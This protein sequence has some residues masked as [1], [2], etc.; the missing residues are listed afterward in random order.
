[1]SGT[2]A[3]QHLIIT[4]GNGYIG[5]AVLR[6]AVQAGRTVCVLGRNSAAVPAGARVCT[7]RLGEALPEAALR[8]DV[9]AAAQAV[10]HLAHDWSNPAGEDGS[11]GLNLAGTRA[12]L[13]GARHHG[14]GRFVF[15]SSQSARQDAANIYGRVKWQVE[16][17]LERPGEVAARIGLVYGGPRQAMFGLLCNLVERAP[18]LPMIDPWRQ[19]QP[20]HLDEVAT[21]LRLLADGAP[22]AGAT[23]W[24]GLAA[25]EG[26][27]FG[28]FLKTL[29]REFA[30]RTLPVLPIRLGLALLAANTAAHI[31]LAPKVDRERILGLAGTRPMACG[32]HLAA[33]GLVLVPLEAG[34]R[35]EPSAQAALQREAHLL[36]GY[37]LG[38]APDPGLAARYAEA[39]HQR[40]E[41]ALALPTGLHS[42]PGLLRLREPLSGAGPLGRRLRLASALAEAT[43]Q[44]EA[45]LAGGSRAGRLARLT[46]RGVADAA[47]LPVRAVFGVRGK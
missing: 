4:G 15:A 38:A 43:P 12:L 41:G 24:F 3:A 26:I 27:A 13:D 22:D 1:M 23:G 6:Q 46:V 10:I 5:A 8:P 33:L 30:G 21:G 11:G 36:L 28:D 7:W 42:V 31:P 39:V 40:G 18:V 14:I 32:A 16:Q 44:G 45:M 35:R 20:I 34:L 2:T 47:A 37:V 19:V 25:P 9:P 17:V 29:A